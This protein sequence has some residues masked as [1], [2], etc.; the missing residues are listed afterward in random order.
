MN[1]RNN[2]FITF[3]IF[4][5]LL[6]LLSCDSTDYPTENYLRVF[7]N[8]VEWEA[9][10]IE[11]SQTENNNG[12]K[13]ISIVAT[14]DLNEAVVIGVQGFESEIQGRTQEITSLANGDFLGYREQGVGTGIETHTSFGCTNVN[15][16]IFIDEYNVSEG[17]ISGTFGGTVCKQGGQNLVTFSSG[18][19]IRLP[20]D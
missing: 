11:V 10:Q 14:A 17:Y 2:N 13:E 15:G 12:E 7:I 9:F 4:V 8:G 20:L 1:Q 19:F 5:F 16:S 6:A 3:S 18:E